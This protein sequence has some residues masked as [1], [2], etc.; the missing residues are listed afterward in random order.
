MITARFVPAHFR[1]DKLQSRVKHID[2]ILM[3]ANTGVIRLK[4][5]SHFYHYT[6][7]IMERM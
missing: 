3:A 7:I 2:L 6:A 4:S 1:L 5:H